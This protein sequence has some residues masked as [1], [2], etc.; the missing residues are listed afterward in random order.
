[1]LFMYL[2]AS[3]FN[4]ISTP[5]G[6]NSGSMG[7]CFSENNTLITVYDEPRLGEIVSVRNE[8][9]GVTHRVCKIE[10]NTFCTCSLKSGYECGWTRKDYLWTVKGVIW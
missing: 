10:N 1:M 4:I 2:I 6:W 3:G 8:V 7:E 5:P 9:Y